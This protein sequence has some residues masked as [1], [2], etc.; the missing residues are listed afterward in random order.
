MIS[1]LEQLFQPL[2]VGPLTLNN[3]VVM[4]PMTR[5]FAPG[6]ILDTRAASYYRRRAEGGVGLILTEG[7]AVNPI[8][9]WKANIPSL[10]GDAAIAAWAPVVK[11]VHDAGAKIIAQL[12]HA[13]L[14][15]VR[16]KAH[17]ADCDSLGP[18]S[19]YAHLPAP[20]AETGFAEGREMTQGDI[21]STIKDYAA[22]ALTSKLLGFDGVELHAAHGYLIDEFFW[23]TTNPR[24][25]RYN[26]D[27]RART[28]FACEIIKAIRHSVGQHFAL[29]LRFSQWKLPS[30]WD[31]QLVSNAEELERFLLPLSG[32][33]LDFFDCSTRRY[34]EPAFTGSSLN[35]AGW[36]KKITAKPCM[37]VGSIGLEGP[38]F[39][40]GNRGTATAS[41]TGSLNNALAMLQRDEV[42][43]VGV[44][45]ALLANP[46]W[47][48]KLR[49]GREVELRPYSADVL[50]T[51]E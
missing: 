2:A 37:T 48:E 38:I 3:R 12:W 33:G 39:E 31:A 15:R 14:G 43:L 1:G 44:G 28:R 45:R 19:K 21:D 5:G 50:A 6:G 49:S 32:A 25:D 7:I 9:A 46:D 8:G 40:G 24:R 17:H 10:F 13:G 47:V 36:S 27:I 11:A 23:S 41:G 4:A 42:D 29:G 20:T 22:A 34:W 16:A 18:G 35:L 30:L 51:L 26:G